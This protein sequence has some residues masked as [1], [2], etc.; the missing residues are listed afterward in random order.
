LLLKRIKWMKNDPPFSLKL[1][2]SN[3]DGSDFSS[4]SSSAWQIQHDLN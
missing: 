1:L 4:S 2:D 3:P